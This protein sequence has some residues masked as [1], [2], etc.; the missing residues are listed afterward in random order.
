MVRG[1]EFE[2]GGLLKGDIYLFF[3]RTLVAGRPRSIRSCL[4]SFGVS[5]I[6]ISRRYIIRELS[7]CLLY[8]SE[9]PRFSRKGRTII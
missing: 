9:S 5:S 8:F 6:P 4:L 7:C 1:F 2:L 3:T